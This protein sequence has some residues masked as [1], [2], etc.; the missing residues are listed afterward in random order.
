[1]DPG[2]VLLYKPQPGG[3]AKQ[4]TGAAKGQ[5][6]NDSPERRVLAR[7][8][9]ARHDYDFEDTYEAG[10]ALQGSEVKSLREGKSSIDDAY[11]EWRRGE[12]YL[13]NASI[14]AY[15]YA[16]ARNHEPMRARKLLLHR[17]EIDRLGTKMRERGFSLIPLE[18]YFKGS[19]VKVELGLGKGRKAHEKRDAKREA[20]AQREVREAMRGHK[21]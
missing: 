12:V 9:R 20:E 1:M 10:L 4:K 5:K 17:Q 7:N 6:R 16:H 3:M 14:Q 2:A 18:L 21:R 19:H 13:V 8:R 15:A 11:C